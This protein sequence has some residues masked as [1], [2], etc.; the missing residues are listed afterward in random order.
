MP[1]FCMDR[2]TVDGMNVEISC[3]EIEENFKKL[4]NGK[5]A[6]FDDIPYEFYKNGGRGVT[7][8]LYTLFKEIWVNERVPDK[9][10]ECKVILLH[11]GGHK[12]KK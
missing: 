7:D 11:K 2:K 4:K 5:A 1:E 9:W 6:G 8:K 10:N 12:S 3:A